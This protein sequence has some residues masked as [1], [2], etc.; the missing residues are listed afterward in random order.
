MRGR[1]LAV[2]LRSAAIAFACAM[3]YAALPRASADQTQEEYDT[4]HD[5][6]QSWT[7]AV[8]AATTE[9]EQEEAI[10]AH[11]SSVPYGADDE[12]ETCVSSLSGWYDLR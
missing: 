6:I 5:W 1:G 3:T 8:E 7:P 2:C 9:E 11:L 12:Y 4:V 10:Y